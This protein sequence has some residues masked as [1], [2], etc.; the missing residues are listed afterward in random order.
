MTTTIILKNIEKRIKII[1]EAYEE[2]YQEFISCRVRNDSKG[3]DK[4]MNKRRKLSRELDALKSA[5]LALKD[6][7]IKGEC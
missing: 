4:A 2:L 7:E 6:F 3:M 1:D 5:K